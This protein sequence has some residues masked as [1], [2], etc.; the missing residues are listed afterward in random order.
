M[1]Y[2]S[3]MSRVSS[4]LYRDNLP[5]ASWQVN[6]G[7]YEWARRLEA[8]D[9]NNSVRGPRYDASIFLLQGGSGTDS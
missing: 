7:Q 9:A 1:A 3:Y 6:M 4:I 8:L 5:W 2:D